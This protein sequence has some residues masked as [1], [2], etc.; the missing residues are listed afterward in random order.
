MRVRLRIS[1]VVVLYELVPAS[2]AALP[3]AWS[4]P[5]ATTAASSSAMSS[6]V[7]SPAA[8]SRGAANEA[9]PSEASAI[10]VVSVPLIV[11]VLRQYRHE[12]WAVIA[13]VSAVPV[14]PLCSS[15]QLTSVHP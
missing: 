15:A 12:R 3:A 2:M 6:P 13:A 1:R 7:G 4:Y 9:S 10:G 11:P 14:P 8:M 5:C